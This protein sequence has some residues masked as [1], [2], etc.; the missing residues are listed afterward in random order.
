VTSAVGSGGVIPLDG[1]IGQ[2]PT[3]ANQFL[4][5][6]G[7]SVSAVDFMIRHYGK[8]A[9]V[10]LIRSYSGGVSDDEAFSAALGVDTAGFNSAWLKDLG[11]AMP[12]AYGPQP[13]PAG[14]LPSGW[15][16]TPVGAA[17]AGPGIAP[18]A[19]PA[20]VAGQPSDSTPAIAAIVAL[21]LVIGCGLL[22]ARARRHGS[23]RL[24]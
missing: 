7:E 12:R 11:A 15:D 9:L 16:S 2:F 18:P 24:P 22:I 4:L 1:L 6:Y 5:A 3:T 23:G 13:A 20:E 21:I 14:P 17:S 19:S 10:K 8:P